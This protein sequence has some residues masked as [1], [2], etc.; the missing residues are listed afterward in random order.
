MSARSTREQEK[1]KDKTW[2]IALAA[3]AG[4][5]TVLGSVFYIL[6]DRAINHDSLAAKAALALGWSALL[7]SK[8]KDIYDLYNNLPADKRAKAVEDAKK[9]LEGMKNSLPPDVMKELT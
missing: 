9:E 1:Q 4:L 8:L 6:Y 3:V 2:L 7:S 5:T